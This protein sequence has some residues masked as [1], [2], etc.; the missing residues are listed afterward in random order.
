MIKILYIS[1]FHL[2]ELKFGGAE[3]N[4]N[5]IINSLQESGCEVTFVKSINIT[6]NFLQQNYYDLKIISNFLFM[7]ELS[8]KEIVR[9]GKYILYEHDHKYLASRNPAFHTNFLA[10]KTKIINRDLYFGA[11][12]V[13]CQSSFQETIIKKNLDINNTYNISGNIWSKKDLNKITE[14]S[15]NKKQDLYSILECEMDSKNMQGAIDFCKQKQYNYELIEDENYYRFLEKISKNIGLVFIP[16]SPETLS[17]I[18]VEARMMG[19]KVITNQ[20]VGVKYE[21]W[22]KKNSEEIISEMSQVREKVTSRILKLI[23]ER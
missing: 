10:P 22:F 12:L 7:D 18:C 23:N 9:Q 13:F 11:N 14:L 16:R 21:D 5:E 6:K 20:L 17:R 15:K 3:Y 1:D 4:D 8:K 2:N 19:C